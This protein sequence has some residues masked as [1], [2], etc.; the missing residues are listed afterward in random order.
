M[1]KPV[2]RQQQEN[3]RTGQRK[4]QTPLTLALD[5][6]C[7]ERYDFI[8]SSSENVVKTAEYF[9]CYTKYGTTFISS[10]F[11]CLLQMDTKYVTI[12][13]VTALISQ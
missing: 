1:P 11:V 4:P 9:Q 7:K 2:R 10:P 6:V 12:T 13:P 8:C 3:T 5:E